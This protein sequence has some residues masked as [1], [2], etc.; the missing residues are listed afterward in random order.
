MTRSWMAILEELRSS[1]HGTV[2][3]VPTAKVEHPL[4]AG[5]KQSVGLWKGQRVDYR[6]SQ[7]D[8]TCLHVHD[9]V[10]H[11][12]VH[13]DEVDPDCDLLMHLL[14]DAPGA[15]I[16]GG[17]AI[18]ALLGGLLGKSKDGALAGAAIGALASTLLVGL[19]DREGE[20]DKVDG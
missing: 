6:W 1:D 7:N 14:R 9:L 16:A 17:T 13:L 12:E 10:D 8:C 11:F 5:M 19:S 3:H 18:G 2:L 4:D 15:S 20:P